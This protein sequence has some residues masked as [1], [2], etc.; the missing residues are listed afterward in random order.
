MAKASEFPKTN[1]MRR[2]DS[3]KI[4]YEVKTYTVDENDLSGT[5]IADQIGIPYE[6]CFKTLVATGDKTGP[7]VFCI[8]C[9]KEIDMKRAASVT[10]NKKIEMIHVKDLLALTGYIRG[11]VS[12]IGMKKSFPTYIDESCLLF[13]KITVSSGTRGA[14][15]LLNVSELLRFVNAKTVTVTQ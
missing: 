1:A 6:Q 15:L 3:A 11:G 9:A 2:L 13:E 8:P 10:G 5:H 7:I 12:P 4:K 14:Q